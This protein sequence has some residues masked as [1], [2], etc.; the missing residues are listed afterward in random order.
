MRSNGLEEVDQC[1][2]RR[3]GGDRTH[4]A[5]AGGSQLQKRIPTTRIGQVN[6]GNG[7]MKGNLLIWFECQ[8]GQ[9]ERVPLNEVPVLLLAR[10]SLRAHRDPL[11]TQE[12]LVPL[13]RLT[14]RC[15]LFGI[16]GHL[17]GDRVE[18]EGVF[19]V[20]QDEHEVRHPFEAIE[21]CR[22]S[23]REEPTAAVAR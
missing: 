10:Q 20:E 19:G 13:E 17:E 9:V 7:Q 23:H 12:P 5:H 2:R 14:S 6:A 15:V 16:P 4:F 8:I 1:P 18:G 3:Q 21:S 22:A 11:V